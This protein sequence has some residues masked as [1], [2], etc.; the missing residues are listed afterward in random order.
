MAIF[1][2]MAPDE[3]A[4]LVGALE[5]VYPN[6]YLR[7]G[8]GQ[9]LVASQGTATDVSNAL[10]IS[11]GKSGPGIVVSVSGYFGR[12]NMNIWDWIKAN[13]VA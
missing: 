5:S 8:P 6:K 1:A 2:I 7:V 11:D 9:W 10:G 3:N 12:A 13:W 4:A